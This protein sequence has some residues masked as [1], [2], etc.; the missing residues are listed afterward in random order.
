[1]PALKEW[2]RVLKPKGKIVITVPNF[3]DLAQSWINEMGEKIDLTRYLTLAQHIYGNQ[4]HEGEFHH[5]PFTPHFMQFIL[6]D[7]GLKSWKIFAYPAMVKAMS[8]DGLDEVGRVY[9]VG[10][11]HVTGTK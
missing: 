8:Y 2:T 10:Q 5:T 11:I 1:V 6:T 9:A 4:F 3:N 7:S